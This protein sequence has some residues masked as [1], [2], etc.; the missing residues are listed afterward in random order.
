MVIVSAASLRLR[1]LQRIYSYLIALALQRQG[2]HPRKP[3]KMLEI[4]EVLRLGR[5]Y[6]PGVDPRAC[7]TAT[8]NHR[9]E[10][11]R[12]ENS[13]RGAWLRIASRDGQPARQQPAFL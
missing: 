5:A 4:L 6:R 3:L 8:L 1:A 2:R 11:H 7:L 13:P 10:G 9:R 12:G